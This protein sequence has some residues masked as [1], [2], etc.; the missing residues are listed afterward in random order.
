MSK[1]MKQNTVNPKDVHISED[2]NSDEEKVRDE[3]VKGLISDDDDDVP[4]VQDNE[5]VRNVQGLDDDDEDKEVELQSV[6]EEK[7]LKSFQVSRKLSK[8]SGLIGTTLNSDSDTSKVP[9]PTSSVTPTQLELIV[10]YMNLC[11]KHNNSKDVNVLA[12]P[13]KSKDLMTYKNEVPEE[14]LK[15]VCNISVK[16]GKKMVYDMITVANYM[17]I[18]GLLHLMC[19]YIAA[20]L[21][22]NSIEDVKKILDPTSGKQF[23][24]C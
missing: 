9:F 20:N 6:D 11:N 5:D 12:F 13:L 1:S 10:E 4:N 15:F 8:M 18:K 14:I 3:D 23:V 17:D 2:D 16:H 7:V 24:N 19:A 21:K 22:G